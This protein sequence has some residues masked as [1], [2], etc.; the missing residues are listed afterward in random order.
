MTGIDQFSAEELRIVV[1]AG[2][3]EY[4]WVPIRPRNEAL[5]CFVDALAARYHLGIDYD[6]ANLMSITELLKDVT[7]R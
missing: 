3:E 7:G 6:R 4:K 2:K 5:D 1:K